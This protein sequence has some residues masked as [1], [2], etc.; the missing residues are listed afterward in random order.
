MVLNEEGRLL[1]LPFNATA[2]RILGDVG[3]FVFGRHL[4]YSEVIHAFGGGLV[5]DVLICESSEIE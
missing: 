5:G 4:K 3:S 2:T 1:R